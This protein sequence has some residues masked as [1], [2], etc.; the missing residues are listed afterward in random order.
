MSENNF[1]EKEIIEES[2]IN[3]EVHEESMDETGSAEEMKNVQVETG[4]LKGSFIKGAASAIVDTVCIGILSIA[5]LYIFEALLKLGGYFISQKINM[6]FIIFVVV[7]ILYT[8][9][10]G[11]I[12]DGKT[13]GKKLLSL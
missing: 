5:V 2:I 12:K 3:E 9:T 10:M 1:E 4:Q 13:I 11:T 8:S 7:S 6:L